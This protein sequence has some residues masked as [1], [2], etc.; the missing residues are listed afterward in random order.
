MSDTRQFPPEDIEFRVWDEMDASGRAKVVASVRYALGVIVLPED[1]EDLGY[2]VA[3]QRAKKLAVDGLIEEPFRVWTGEEVRI[4]YLHDP[5][6]A[7]SELAAK[8]IS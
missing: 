1:I 2:E 4:K 7:M 5:L 3:I 6:T 8:V